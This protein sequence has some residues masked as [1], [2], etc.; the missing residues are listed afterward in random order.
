MYK[1]IWSASYELGTVN[2]LK[3]KLRQQ[4]KLS[5]FFHYYKLDNYT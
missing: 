3:L 4:V 5:L 1:T 2:K